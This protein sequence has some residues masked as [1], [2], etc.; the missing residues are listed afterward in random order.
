VASSPCVA[1]SA[2]A[3]TGI[4]YVDSEHTCSKN[5]TYSSS[6]VTSIHPCTGTITS[7]HTHYV[8]G[9]FTN[10][11][12]PSTY[13]IDSDTFTAD[14]DPQPYS[15]SGPGSSASAYTFDSYQEDAGTTAIYPRANTGSSEAITYVIL[16]LVGEAG[17]IAN[18]YKKVLRDNNGEI[19]LD[20]LTAIADEIGDV[21][22]Y[23]ARLAEEFGLQLSTIAAKNYNKL[24]Q[25]KSRNVLHGSGDDR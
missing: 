6:K 20:K 13:E 4:T 18:K 10:L 12:S 23:C 21:I 7:R 19:D 25:R 3:Y 9:E 8:E 24:N 16:G 2:Q 22:W 11:D 17:E 15:L 14:S 5:P 1:C